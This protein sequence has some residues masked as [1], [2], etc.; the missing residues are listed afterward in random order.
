MDPAN[1]EML[2]SRWRGT[3]LPEMGQASGPKT[4]GRRLLWSA[5]W[6]QQR[7]VPRPP[8]EGGIL[9][10][11]QHLV[12]EK[13]ASGG[14][15]C[16]ACMRAKSLQSCP[17]LCNPI[18]WSLAGSSIHGIL[19]ARILE[20][21]AKSSSRGSSQ[22]RHHTCI[23]YLCLLHWQMGSLPLAPPGKKHTEWQTFGHILGYLL[24]RSL[25]WFLGWGQAQ[26]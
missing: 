25:L 1:W 12:T 18:D 15:G 10:R 20:W 19:Q 16:R 5:E 13:P 22:L 26:T 21:V 11:E 6:D 7:E 17:T 4:T 24:A 8:R 9:M 23:Y 2:R 3:K 14:Q